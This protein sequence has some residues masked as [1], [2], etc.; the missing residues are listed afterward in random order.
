VALYGD[1]LAELF[2]DRT[3]NVCSTD[4][5][6]F[7][8]LGKYFGKNCPEKRSIAVT[9]FTTFAKLRKATISFIMSVCPSIRPMEKLGFQWK[10]FH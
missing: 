2:P 7:V 10:D 6:V 9:N 5:I 3:Q 8:I 4:Y 1:L